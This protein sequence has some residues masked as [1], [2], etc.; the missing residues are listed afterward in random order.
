M[1]KVGVSDGDTEAKPLGA[2]RGRRHH[3]E[4]VSEGWAL[5]ADPDLV[6]A[7]GLGI[8]EGLDQ[9]AGRRFRKEPHADRRTAWEGHESNAGR[10]CSTNAPMVRSDVSA[11]CPGMID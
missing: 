7:E 1:T 9:F 2:R 8:A 5:V 11:S 4:R 6:Q 10:T 3:R